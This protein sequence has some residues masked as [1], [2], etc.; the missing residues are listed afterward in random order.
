MSQTRHPD[1]QISHATTP[2]PMATAKGRAPAAAEPSAAGTGQNARER[3]L[4]QPATHQR[5]TNKA[6]GYMS[7]PVVVADHL[8]MHLA[9][10]RLE[11]IE[12][13]TGRSRWRSEQRFGKYWSMVHQDDKIFALDEDGMLYLLRANPERLEILDSREVASQPSWGHLAVSGDQ[14][15]VRELGALR[16][17]R[18]GPAETIGQMTRLW[19]PLRDVALLQLLLPVAG[20]ALFSV[21][22]VIGTIPALAV[23]LMLSALL[24]KEVSASQTSGSEAMPK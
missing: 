4:M 23:M 14:L 20:F 24:L 22:G 7:T 13:E 6:T 9:N 16:A 2:K 17:F 21:L 19:W 11:C 8:Y 5:W 18:I 15:F 1:P 10:R 12:L 3:R